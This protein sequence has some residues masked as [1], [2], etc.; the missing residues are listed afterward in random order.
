MTP[1]QLDVLFRVHSGKRAT[2]T[3][4]DLMALAAMAG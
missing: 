4:A 3:G 2:G 1:A